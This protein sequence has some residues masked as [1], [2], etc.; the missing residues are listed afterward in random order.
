MI[1]FICPNWSNYEI[2][3]YLDMLTEFSSFHTMESMLEKFTVAF[4][5]LSGFLSQADSIGNSKKRTRSVTSSSNISKNTLNSPYLAHTPSVSSLS[6]AENT[7]YI[8]TRHN[9]SAASSLLRPNQD[10]EPSYITWWDP[11]KQKMLY[12]DKRTGN[13]YVIFFLNILLNVNNIAMQISFA[14]CNTNF[15]HA[16]P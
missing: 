3:L 13:S 9:N 11:N 2:N 8:A 1:R 12:I 16:A 6:T 5:R 7:Q 15:K 4:L 14:A 10:N